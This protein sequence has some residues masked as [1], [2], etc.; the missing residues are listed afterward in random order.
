MSK[1]YSISN[2]LIPNLSFSKKNILHNVF[3]I[4]NWKTF[5]NYIKNNIDIILFKDILYDYTWKTFGY[6]KLDLDYIISSY[7]IYFKNNKKINESI[8]RKIIKKN[9]DKDKIHKNII[10]NI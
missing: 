1:I 6:V 9:I 5:N 8:I 10:K 4:K 2:D 7:L 3:N